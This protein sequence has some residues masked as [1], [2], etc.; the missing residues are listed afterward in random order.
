MRYHARMKQVM[1]RSQQQTPDALA[2]LR[3]HVRTCQK[4]KELAVERQMSAASQATTAL[5]QLASSEEAWGVAAQTLAQQHSHVKTARAAFL[6]TKKRTVAA[7]KELAAGYRALQDQSAKVQGMAGETTEQLEALHH[8]EREVAKAQ[9]NRD[10]WEKMRRLNEGA[11]ERTHTRNERA[12]IVVKA[13]ENEIELTQT[14][15]TEVE[16][17][18]DEDSTAADRLM[19]TALRGILLR[20]PTMQQQTREQHDEEGNPSVHGS[21]TSTSS[22]GHP[23]AGTRSGD[24]MSPDLGWTHQAQLAELEA[25]LQATPWPEVQATLAAAEPELQKLDATC[26]DMLGL[27]TARSQGAARSPRNRKGD[28]VQAGRAVSGS[29]HENDAKDRGMRMQRRKELH[30]RKK[31]DMWWM[32]SKLLAAEGVGHV[33]AQHT[34]MDGD[35]GVCAVWMHEHKDAQS[36]PTHDEVRAYRADMVEKAAKMIEEWRRSGDENDAALAEAL[37]SHIIVEARDNMKQAQRKQS[38]T[39][40]EALARFKKPGTW[41]TIGILSAACEA[42]GCGVQFW[43]LNENGTAVIYE[44]Q[45]L[46]DISNAIHRKHARQGTTCDRDLPQNTLNLAHVELL[47]CRL[48]RRTHVNDAINWTGGQRPNHFLLMKVD[49]CVGLHAMLPCFAT[50]HMVPWGTAVQ[51]LVQAG[52]ASQG[53]RVER[54]RGRRKRWRRAQHVRPI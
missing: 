6:D 5:N 41:M 3:E 31:A 52:I 25:E 29:R 46:R 9:S 50:P 30:E 32:Q 39:L 2:S 38:T 10:D 16:R 8:A 27:N 20:N 13:W 19:E 26:R 7:M 12:T 14:Q 22:A 45:L 37:T 47:A 48:R 15:L 51:S 53:P 35:C 1:S 49:K 24:N 23:R 42:K 36:P 34:S 28:N 17:C 18:L 11:Q 21:D 4:Q 54:N 40:A 33:V 44:E 43:T